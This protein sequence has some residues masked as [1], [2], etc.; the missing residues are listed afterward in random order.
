MSDRHRLRTLEMRIR[1]HQGL[2]QRSRTI[3]EH[4]LQPLEFSVDA[5]GGI[6]HPEARAGG[7]LVVT[8]PSGMQTTS[9]FACLLM[10]QPVDESMNV[11][12]RSEWLL[13]ARDTPPDPIK[14]GPDLL[15]L[16]S[17]QYASRHESTRPRFRERDIEWPKADVRADGAIH[18][19]E[20]G[21]RSTGEAATPELVGLP[22]LAGGW[23]AHLPALSSKGDGSAFGRTSIPFASRSLMARTRED[24]P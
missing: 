15:C 23:R 12:I 2:E 14:A 17:G 6:H 18:S 3:D 21:G 9:R 20:F 16:S 5:I 1:R 10:Q 13:A 22:V 11:L 4:A 7:H 19:L 24:R 8:T